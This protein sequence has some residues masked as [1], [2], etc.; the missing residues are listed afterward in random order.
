MTEEVLKP[1]MFWI[2]LET[3]G[4]DAQTEVPLEIGVILTDRYLNTVDSWK[5]IIWEDTGL[6]IKAARDCVD[7]VKDMHTKNGLWADID[8]PHTH[9]LER[10]TI[11]EVLCDWL[12]LSGVEP[13]TFSMAG[14]SIGSL[15]RPFV[16]EHFPKL[17]EFLH[18]R[19]IDIS[20]IKEL[21]RIWRP[22]LLEAYEKQAPS[23]AKWHRVLEDAQGSIDEYKFYIQ[24]GFI[25]IPTSDFL[26]VQ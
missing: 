22:D 6:Y 14:S 16:Q 19:N 7:F 9:V 10:K 20:S 2:D 11:D 15:D 3:T 25:Q 17:N 8:D 21:C 4:L 23:E 18:Y 24:S 12:E 5:A 1:E 13:R 26:K